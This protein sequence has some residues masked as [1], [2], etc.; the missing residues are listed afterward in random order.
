MFSFNVLNTYIR[1]YSQAFPT[2][3]SFLWP[4][5]RG[6][7]ILMQSSDTERII[8]CPLLCLQYTFGLRSEWTWF[9]CS[10]MFTWTYYGWAKKINL[11]FSSL[12][13]SILFLGFLATGTLRRVICKKK[14]KKRRV[15]YKLNVNNKL[16]NERIGNR[17]NTRGQHKFLVGVLSTVK[18]CNWFFL[19]DFL[20]VLLRKIWWTK[21]RA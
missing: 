16:K 1:K 19:W 15:I 6:V 13:F 20:I 10:G 8:L 17:N 3:F 4:L 2:G 11:F 14:K 9:D 18:L 7:L 12:L 21:T 5:F